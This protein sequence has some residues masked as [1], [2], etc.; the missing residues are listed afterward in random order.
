MSKRASD[1]KRRERAKKTRN[2]LWAFA[3]AAGAPQVDESTTSSPSNAP[4]QMHYDAQVESTLENQITQLTGQVRVLTSKMA[5]KESSIER[6]ECIIR[7]QAARIS[8][9]VD[10]CSDCH[11]TT[12]TGP[13]VCSE[14]DIADGHDDVGTRVEAARAAALTTQEKFEQQALLV[15]ERNAM[16]LEDRA[17]I[18]L[19]MGEVIEDKE[20]SLAYLS[21]ENIRLER[22]MGYLSTTNIQLDARVKL[23]EA[24]KQLA[25]EAPLF[26]E[27]NTALPNSQSDLGSAKPLLHIAA[28]RGER[29]E[30]YAANIEGQFWWFTGAELAQSDIRGRS[31]NKRQSE[32][33]EEITSNDEDHFPQQRG[34]RQSKHLQ[35]AARTLENGLIGIKINGSYKDTRRVRAVMLKNAKDKKSER[36]VVVAK[37]LPKEPLKFKLTETEVRAWL[38]DNLKGQ[39]FDVFK[40]VLKRLE[41]GHTVIQQH[42]RGNYIVYQCSQHFNCERKYKL[43]DHL[44][45]VEV[46]QYGDHADVDRE[47]ERT[48]HPAEVYA[49]MI[50][51]AA[52]ENLTASDIF[53][54]LEDKFPDYVRN[55]GI[56]RQQV[57]DFVASLPRRRDVDVP[58]ITNYFELEREFARDRLS[59]DIIDYIREDKLPRK[60]FVY[61][62]GYWGDPHFA[63]IVGG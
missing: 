2:Q 52:K 50:D 32:G 61:H 27:G 35:A 43:V 33:T 31:R 15:G 46:L 19:R 25:R 36:V 56:T 53:T 28:G 41:L 23:L 40:E 7:G 12:Q 18:M 6:K 58:C 29:N 39:T 55:N 63:C 57:Q 21:G 45:R 24:E 9:L 30:S 42:K 13:G 22:E 20:A 4:P 26:R 1:A 8:A 11:V 59:N 47:R 51:Q 17:G 14:T 38:G 49:C 34:I 3:E 16:S 37:L 60:E 10:R 44:D 62:G 54:N 48:R 5:E